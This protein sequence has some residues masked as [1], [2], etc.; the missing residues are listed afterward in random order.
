MPALF[1]AAIPVDQA[2]SALIDGIERR[3]SRVGAPAWVLPMLAVRG[4]VTTVMDEVMIR[5][6]R[7]SD[8]IR[9]SET[10]ER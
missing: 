8:A 2:G 1:T 7:L 4:V 6:G 3:A 10:R 5:N 9:Q